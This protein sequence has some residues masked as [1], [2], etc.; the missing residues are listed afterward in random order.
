MKRAAVLLATVLLA[1]VLLAI[2]SFAAGVSDPANKHNLSVSGGGPMHA[3]GED[4]ICV[5][6]HTPHNSNPAAPLWNHALT[7]GV[8]YTTYN[9][10][11]MRA[12][13]GEP[14]GSSKLCLSCHDGTV[15]LGN[16]VNNG[17]IPFTGVDAQGHMQGASVLG[18]NVSDDHPFSFAPVTGSEIVLPP[19][20][21]TVKLDANGQVQCRSCHDPHVNDNDSASNKFLVKYNRF[22]ALCLTCHQKQYWSSNPSSHQSTARLY[23]AAQ[24]AH[25][26]YTDVASNGCESCHK[27]HSAATG[28]RVLKG[29]EE[30]TCGTGAGQQCHGANNVA[31][32]NIAAEFNKTYSHPTYRTT[33]SAHDESESP[34]NATF[35]MPEDSPAA[36]RHAECPDCH[37]AHSAYGFSATAPKAPGALSGMWGIDTNGNQVQPAGNPPSVNEYEICYKCHAD[38]ANKPQVSGGPW[39]PY[40][41]RQIVQFNMRLMMDPTNPSFHPVEGPGR[42]SFVPSLIFPWTTS[43]RLYCTDCHNNDALAAGGGPRGPHGSNYKHILERRYDMEAEYTTESATNYALCYKCHDRQNIQDDRSFKKHKLHIVDVRASCSICHDPHGISLTQGNSA[44]NNHLINFDL[45]F[46]TPSGSGILRFD[47]LGIG[48]GRCYLTC[49]GENHDPE[50]Y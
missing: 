33:P 10:S 3:S 36:E 26:G 12:T 35:R 49:H 41:T 20:G 40:P 19:A 21:D 44:N 46:V 37:N 45:R 18:T 23:T 47:D 17:N 16:T 11:T 15:A 34:S 8:S 14:S 4:E 29:Q 48:R 30:A 5:Y 25:T 7:S 24:G 38:S 42:N 9:S 2:L 28:Q 39:P 50:T 1:T 13:V 6:C 32:Y 43:S 31:D 22:S 27:P